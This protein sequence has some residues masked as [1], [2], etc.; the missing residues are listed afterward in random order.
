MSVSLTSARGEIIIGTDKARAAVKSLSGDLK[1]FA[2]STAGFVGG[3]S[4]AIGAVLGAGF[5]AGISKAADF[6][7]QLSAIQSVLSATDDQM[8]GLSDAI[9]SVGQSSSFTAGEVGQVAENLA[10]MG[11]SAEDMVAGALRAVTDLAAA[12]GTVPENAAM[13]VG[14]AMNQ[15]QLAGDQAEGVADIFTRTANAS[16]ADVD[17]L[18]VSFSY[19]AGQAHALGIPIEDLMTSFAIL[20]DNGQQGSKAGTGLGRAFTTLINPTDKA[21]AAMEKW[22]I[23]AL[24]ASGNFVGIPNLIDQLNTS[25]AGMTQSQKAA[26]LSEIFVTNG[27]RAMLPLLNA[28][29]DLAKETGKSWD[30]YQKGVTTGLTASEAA[31]KRL[32]NLSGSVE[33]FKGSIDTILIKLGMLFLGPLKSIV[34]LATVFTN[35]LGSMSESSYALA[36]ALAAPI[37]A[38]GALRIAAILAYNPILR[39]LPGFDAFAKAAGKAALPVAVLVGG[40]AL[41]GLAYKKNFGGLHDWVD[42]VK[43]QFKTIKDQFKLLTQ[44]TE[45][46]GIFDPNTGEQIFNTSDEMKSLTGRAKVLGDVIKKVTGIDM[47]KW[48]LGMANATERFPKAFNKLKTQLNQIGDVIKDKGLIAGIKDFFGEGGKGVAEAFGDGLSAVPKF[49]GDMLKNI[50]TGNDTLDHILH[51]SGKAFTD[52]GRLIQELGQG[53]FSGFMDVLDRLGN[54]LKDLTVFTLKVLFNVAVDVISDVVDFGWDWILDKVFGQN[55]VFNSQGQLISSEPHKETLPDLLLELGIRAI[56]VFKG[57]FSFAGDKIGDL[58]H[59]VANQISG[60]GSGA[61][62]LY[63]SS[64]DQIYAG[65]N[66][67]EHDVLVSIG[68]AAKAIWNGFTNVVGDLWSWVREQAGVNAVMGENGSMD[69]ARGYSAA[70]GAGDVVLAILTKFQ[71]VWNGIDWGGESGPG[72]WINSHIVQPIIVP[73]VKA[74]IS[75]TTVTPETEKAAFGQGEKSG[76]SFMQKFSEGLTKALDKGWDTVAGVFGGGGGGGGGGKKGNAPLSTAVENYAIGFALGVGKVML[77]N[78]TTNWNMMLIDPAKGL[79]AIIKKGVAAYFDGAGKDWS[80]LKGS[81]SNFFGGLGKVIKE[82]FTGTSG[83]KTGLFD[84]V[85]GDQL[86][87]DEPGIFD[88]IGDILK[89]SLGGSIARIDWSSLGSTIGDVKGKILGALKDALP[90]GDD[91]SSLLSG[92]FSFGGGTAMAAEAPF[93]GQE[94]R[95]AILG[96][97]GGSGGIAGTIENWFLGEIS[98][99]KIKVSGWK[100]DITS[101]IGKIIPDSLPDLK[102]PDLKIDFGS[103]ETKVNELIGKIGGWKDDIVEAWNNFWGDKEDAQNNVQM[104]P[105]DPATQFFDEN[106]FVPQ[107]PEPIQQ[108]PDFSEQKKGII[109]V[110]AD[111]SPAQKTIGAYTDEVSTTTISTKLTAEASQ[112]TATMNSAVLAGATFQN[113]IWTTHLNADAGQF[114]NTYTSAW[115]AGDAFDAQ[116][117]EATFTLDVNPAMIAAAAAFEIGR[118]WDGSDNFEATFLLDVSPAMIAAAAAFDMGRAW[119]GQVFTASF[120][121]DTSGL[122]AAAAKADQTAAHIAA[123]MPHSPAKE[124]PLKEPIKFDYIADEMRGSMDSMVAYTRSGVASAASLLRSS[125]VTADM[126]NSGMA[127]QANMARPINV[128][129]IVVNTMDPE[130]YGQLLADARFGREFGEAYYEELDLTE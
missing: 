113:E 58:V 62:G 105:T 116:T 18:G 26:A 27:A 73:P 7:H 75:V 46:S 71:A 111:L 89:K 68:V 59:W 70:G 35:A 122:D 55:D 115:Q 95:N 101:A 49:F 129:N 77:D 22:N 53:D 74:T 106:G 94:A 8:E 119:G 6:E 86:L 117:W 69:P 87:G 88:E 4:T 109:K 52:F 118:A 5:V 124:G 92:I 126:L 42:G 65:Q 79:G 93:A 38:F 97:S 123:V 56:G 9:L 13:I 81:V 3:A 104:T 67:S 83:N 128:T 15:Y 64:G 61:T 14:Q 100:D 76:Q 44:P 43:D 24:D 80:S 25:F 19:A 125:G 90:S 36:A 57:F 17:S 82:N 98:S 103:V 72:P 84:P 30:D 12:T 47:R 112:F 39:Y 51:E 107:N 29:S 78:F 33:K 11:I 45:Q 66:A 99:L 37:A 2:S 1:G 28:Q 96:G 54:R 23:H 130:H 85:T 50:S 21:A 41:L 110:D 20:A 127:N 48:L 63:D 108:S 60:R 31:A 10:K 91:I 32:D 121:V 16:A 34:D 102:L 40:I 120:S 114:T